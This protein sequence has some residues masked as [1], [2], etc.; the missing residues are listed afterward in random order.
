MNSPGQAIRPI[1]VHSHADLTPTEISTYYAARVPL[2][3]F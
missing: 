2:L 1:S 3:R